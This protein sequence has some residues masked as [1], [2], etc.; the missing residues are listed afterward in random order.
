ML[1]ITRKK[2]ESV[3]IGNE[4]VV[5]ICDIDRGK[6][7]VGIEAPKTILIMRKELLDADHR[8]AKATSDD[9]DYDPPARVPQ[10]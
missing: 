2:G 6:V 5:T 4:I 1:V 10:L 8:Q 9:S 3:H 7:R